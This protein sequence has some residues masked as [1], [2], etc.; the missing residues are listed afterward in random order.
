MSEPTWQQKAKESKNRL[1]LVMKELL[2]EA[3]YS[4]SIASPETLIVRVKYQDDMVKIPSS[5][6]GYSI[7][8]YVASDVIFF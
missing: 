7:E 1:N 4:I 3:Y 6:E 8:C 5:F 2:G